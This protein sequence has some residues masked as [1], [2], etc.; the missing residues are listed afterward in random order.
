MSS[1]TF[2]Q[3][4]RAS[5]RRFVTLSSRTHGSSMLQSRTQAALREAPP[6]L[7]AQR[8]S[9]HG[10]AALLIRAASAQQTGCCGTEEQP[11]SLRRRTRPPS[12]V[13]PCPPLTAPPGSP[14][15]VLD[16][17]TFWEQRIRCR[18]ELQ[19]ALARTQQDKAS[20][21]VRQVED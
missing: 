4:W 12:P 10:K 15:L 14:A 13:R 17:H 1:V 2:P 5:S 21:F 9:T 18:G 3:A 20:S 19:D 7:P 8:S 16:C 11:R 6:A